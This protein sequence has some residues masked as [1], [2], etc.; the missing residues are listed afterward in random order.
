MPS[1]HDPGP[2]PAQA[3]PAAAHPSQDAAQP[4]APQPPV[5][6]A[7]TIVQIPMAQ[8]QDL[9]R[10]A[11]ERNQLELERIAAQKEEQ[12]READLM[13][14]AGKAEEAIKAVRDQAAREVA[15]KEERLRQ[16]EQRSRTYARDSMLAAEIAQVRGLNP[17]QVANV[18]RLLR[19]G[20]EAHPEGDGYVVRTPHTFQP[21]K[22][23]VADFFKNP[24][25]AC[26]LMPTTQ[27][28]VASTGA[29]QAAPTPAGTPPPPAPP[30]NLI[31][32]IRNFYAARAPAQAQPARNMS[33]PFGLKP[34]RN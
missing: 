18:T 21:V 16:T 3:E 13:V 8:L 20:L 30:P 7:S 4:A 26:F 17:G 15:E 14:K 5:N 32:D 11:Q 33:E 9:L 24:D 22:E 6:P 12:A 23:Y 19:D 34:K 28:G 2:M 25:N 1:T 29:H 31:G 10:Q 27:G